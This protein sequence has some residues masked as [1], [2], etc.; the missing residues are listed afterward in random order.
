VYI[1]ASKDLTQQSLNTRRLTTRQRSRFD[2][3]VF[4][5]NHLLRS[6][7][8]EIWNAFGDTGSLLIRI[9]PEFHGNWLARTSSDF[10]FEISRRLAC[11]RYVRYISFI[12]SY[13]ECPFR[14]PR[15]HKRAFNHAFHLTSIVLALPSS[16]ASFSPRRL[17]KSIRVHVRRSIFFQRYAL[18]SPPS[19]DDAGITRYTYP[20]HC[21]AYKA[22]RA[23]HCR[24]NI[25]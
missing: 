13:R 6:P 11:F 9:R 18:F 4:T 12:S 24:L 5:N 22:G 20:A 3:G 16:S 17:A 19:E 1:L 15:V 8:P 23:P 21:A 14:Y 10:A 25:G 2:L 7:R